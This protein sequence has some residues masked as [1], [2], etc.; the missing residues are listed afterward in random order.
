MQSR[1]AWSSESD[2]HRM[3]RHVQWIGRALLLLFLLAT[4]ICLI[5]YRQAAWAA[6]VPIPVI[7]GALVIAKY[8]ERQSRREVLG[9]RGNRTL[10]APEHDLDLEVAGVA[11]IFKVLALLAL[12]CLIIAAS[13]FELAIVGI[14]AAALF[15]LSVLIELP[16]L[17]LFFGESQREEDEKLSEAASPATGE[18]P[19]SP[20]PPG[21]A[22][23]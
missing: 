2:A 18:E 21:S 1:I 17:F 23:S 22:S 5:F 20:A 19:S 6:A 8:Y 13:F 15:F 4:I 16:Y 14:L 9:E 7:Y 10:S 12:G 3:T 11:T